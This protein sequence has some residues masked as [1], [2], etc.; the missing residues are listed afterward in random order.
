MTLSKG[1]RQWGGAVVL[2]SQPE[3]GEKSVTRHC[4]WA[5]KDKALFWAEQ[6]R[7]EIRMLGLLLP[8]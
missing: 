8:N 7:Q 5:N 3:G 1:D 2:R 6:P 4:H